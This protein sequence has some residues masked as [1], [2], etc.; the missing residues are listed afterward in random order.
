MCLLFPSFLHRSEEFG[1]AHRSEN[2]LRLC[3]LNCFDFAD[4]LML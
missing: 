2:F 4:Y 1:F 3:L